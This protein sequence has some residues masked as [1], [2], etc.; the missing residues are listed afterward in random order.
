MTKV[1][2]PLALAFLLGACTSAYQTPTAEG[3]SQSQVSEAELAARRQERDMALSFATEYK[4]QGSYR[5]A[6][7]NYSKVFRLDPELEKAAHLKYWSLCYSQLGQAD[8]ALVVME[9]AVGKRPEEHYE[10]VSL[11]RL[12]ENAGQDDKALPQYREAVRL[13][14]D[15][16]ESWKS[17]KKL[18]AAKADAS[19]ELEDWKAV[20]GVL[21]TLIALNPTETSYLE[22]KTRITK[23]NFSAED[24]IKSLE[25][26]VAADPTNFRARLD[27]SRAYMDFAS[28][29]SYRKAHTL[30]QVLA[31]E[32]GDNLQVFRLLADCLTELDDLDGAIEALK[33]V[34]SLQ[35]GDA[36]TMVRIG[37][38]Y[39]EQK[40]LKVARSWGQKARAKAAGGPGLILLAQVAEAAV[41]QCADGALK[42]Y[43]KLAY[44][45]AA[46]YYDQVTDPATKGTARNRREALAPVLPTTGD[47][48]LNKGKTLAGH[49]CYGW[50]VE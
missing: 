30:L 24:V 11:A 5:E 45:L 38:L 3:P 28:P 21:D 1:L 31:R 34:D 4:K 27:L 10:R 26:Q 44:E 13:K 42:Y 33:T 40:Q 29:E 36:P 48:F 18:L 6:A 43:D 32:Q 15:D 50:L 37:G 49:A 2:L 19:G 41:D 14:A 7:D 35:G 8:S 16:E 25:E 9:L 20:L 22:E 12:Y 17:V 47:Q 23:R 46:S 39:L